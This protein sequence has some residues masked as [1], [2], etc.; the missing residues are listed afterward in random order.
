MVVARKKHF[1]RIDWTEALLETEIQDK[2]TETYEG[3]GRVKKMCESFH[4]WK[5]NTF[6]TFF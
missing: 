5:S 2:L 4:M 1:D 3:K 6:Y